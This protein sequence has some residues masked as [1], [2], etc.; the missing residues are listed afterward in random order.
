[1]LAA[2]NSACRWRKYAELPPVN[3][4]ASAIAIED[5]YT[6]TVPRVSRSS[7]AHSTPLSYSARCVRPGLM[8]RSTEP[9]F[10]REAKHL[11]AMLVVAE[12]VEARAGGRQQH[13]VAPARRLARQR[14]R[15]LHRRGAQD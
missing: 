12:H 7:A 15:L 2:R 10:H 4:L 13:H 8:L 9:L 6:I 5:E 3:L 11:A 1:M 14:H